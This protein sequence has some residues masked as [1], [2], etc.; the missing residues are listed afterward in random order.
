MFGKFWKWFWKTIEDHRF[1]S[2][3]PKLIYS[4]QS[5]SK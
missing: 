2:K 4:D 5:T 1:T 3:L